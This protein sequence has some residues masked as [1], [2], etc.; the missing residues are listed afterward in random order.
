[1]GD[2]GS[3]LYKLKLETT[4]RV[5]LL[6]IETSIT[7]LALKVGHIN[8]QNLHELSFGSKSPR[9]PYILITKQVCNDYIQSK[10]HWDERPRH[11]ETRILRKNEMIHLIYVVHFQ[12]L[13]LLAPNIFCFSLMITI[14]RHGHIFLKEKNSTFE[15]LKI[16]KVLVENGGEMI[17]TL[18]SDKGGQYMSHEF[19]SLLEKYGI[20]KLLITTNSPH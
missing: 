9:M 4:Q 12:F 6:A 8:Y 10:Q 15:N 7:K 14:K 19:S 1:M 17:S 20:R 2:Q 11:N 18:R 5:I 16:F 13:H 3:G